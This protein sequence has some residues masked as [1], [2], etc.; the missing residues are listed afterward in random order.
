MDEYNYKKHAFPPPP[1]PLQLKDGVG[2]TGSDKG[3]V[4]TFFIFHPLE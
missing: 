3:Y 4:D 2:R 1:V